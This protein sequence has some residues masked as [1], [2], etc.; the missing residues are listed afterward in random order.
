MRIKNL[1]EILESFYIW[2]LLISLL[3]ATVIHIAKSYK[4]HPACIIQTIDYI[5]SSTS[6]KKKAPTYKVSLGGI[7]VLPSTWIGTMEKAA[8][9]AAVFLMNFLLCILFSLIYVSP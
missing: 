7:W 6:N 1:S 9:A 5:I 3:C 2:K 4:F 8:E